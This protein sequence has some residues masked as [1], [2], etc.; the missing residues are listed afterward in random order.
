MFINLC[1]FCPLSHERMCLIVTPRF[2][3]ILRIYRENHEGQSNIAVPDV[4]SDLLNPTL[5]L[6]VFSVHYRT[7]NITLFALLIS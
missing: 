7:P 5:T 3:D 6:T 1:F 4:D 2:E